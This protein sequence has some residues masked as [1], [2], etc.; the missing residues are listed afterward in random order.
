MRFMSSKN[1][2]D[3]SNKVQEWTIGRDCGF[4]DGTT[5]RQEKRKVPIYVMAEQR[6]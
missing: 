3:V 5:I 4:E 1:N 2:A 6:K